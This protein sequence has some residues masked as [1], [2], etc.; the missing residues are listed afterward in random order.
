[1]LF[2][3]ERSAAVTNQSGSC[4]RHVVSRDCARINGLLGTYRRP[5]PNFHVADYSTSFCD[6]IRRYTCAD[7]GI[8]FLFQK[9]H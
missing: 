1:V 9:W 4:S 3:G 6:P 8:S 7:S 2:L 5:H